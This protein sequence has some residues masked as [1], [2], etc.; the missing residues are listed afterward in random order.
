MET[1]HAYRQ[2]YLRVTEEINLLSSINSKSLLALL[3]YNE[4]MPDVRV[5]IGCV[6][7]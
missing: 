6:T 5:D 3:S 2:G 1:F 7:G 4:C